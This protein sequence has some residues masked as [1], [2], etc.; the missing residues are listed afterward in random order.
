MYQEFA[1]GAAGSGPAPS[2]STS[3]VAVIVRGAASTVSLLL[4]ASVRS[5]S[6][7]NWRMSPGTD[8]AVTVNPHTRSALTPA[9]SGT[10][11]DGTNEVTV[12]PVDAVSGVTDEAEV[13]VRGTDPSL[14]TDIRTST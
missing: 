13:I 4:N 5:A 12:A 11:M 1:A 10:G 9:A 6:V 7:R 3:A 8:P 2:G 14:V